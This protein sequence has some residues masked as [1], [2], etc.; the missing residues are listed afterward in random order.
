MLNGVVQKE[1]NIVANARKRFG[2]G[3]SL[4]RGHN[5]G[6]HDVAIACQGKHVT[7]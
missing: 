6:A 3:Q 4:V 5:T 7:Q 2:L 1:T